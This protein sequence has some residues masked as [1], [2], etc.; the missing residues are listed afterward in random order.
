VDKYA[1][2]ELNRVNRA[3][4]TKGVC[5]TCPASRH[6]AMIGEALGK[7]QRFAMIEEEPEHVAVSILSTV[8]SLWKA[9]AELR[10]LKT[11]FGIPRNKKT[12]W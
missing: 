5:V 1:K 6:A 3:R 4:N 7:R 10:R 12:G 8:A 2:R 11:K 9:R